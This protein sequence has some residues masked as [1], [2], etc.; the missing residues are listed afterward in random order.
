LKLRELSLKEGSVATEMS[1]AAPKVAVHREM[2]VLRKA[3]SGA[4]G[5]FALVAGVLGP[6]FVNLAAHRSGAMNRKI[7]PSSAATK[8]RTKE[9]KSDQMIGPTDLPKVF[10]T[11]PKSQRPGFPTRQDPADGLA[12]G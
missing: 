4:V 2:T 3:L 9:F 11:P 5:F 1:I 6:Q 8:P 7:E 10:F 12:A